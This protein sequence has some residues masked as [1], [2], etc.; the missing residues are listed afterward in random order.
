LIIGKFGATATFLTYEQVNGIEPFREPVSLVNLLIFL[1]YDSAPGNQVQMS[2][3]R[4]GHLAKNN[5]V[6]V[7]ANLKVTVSCRQKLSS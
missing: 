5:F 3:F 6:D 2:L 7:N 4:N 1:Q